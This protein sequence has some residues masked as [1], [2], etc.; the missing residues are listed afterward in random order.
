[1]KS[2]R[3]LREQAIQ[4]EG[5]L[6]NQVVGIADVDGEMRAVAKVRTGAKLREWPMA[7]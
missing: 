7:A 4:K 6:D 2:E 3:G 1:M 5:E